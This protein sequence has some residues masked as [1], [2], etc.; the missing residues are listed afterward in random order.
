MTFFWLV[1]LF[2]GTFQVTSRAFT[3]SSSASLPCSTSNSAQ[4]RHG[5]ADRSGLKERGGRHRSRP[6]L[7]RHAI[8]SGLFDLA[9]FYDGEGEAGDVPLRASRTPTTSSRASAAS[10][11][12]RA[13]AGGVDV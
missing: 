6:C 10:A 11:A 1:N 9:V 3:S 8:A 13:A 2:S 7:L 4:R 12:G 5:L